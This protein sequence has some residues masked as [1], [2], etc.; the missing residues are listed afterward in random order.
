MVGFL[1]ICRDLSFI[2]A[3]KLRA[4][5]MDLKNRNKL[6]FGNISLKK[7]QLK[8]KLIEFNIV[9]ERQLLG[10]EE[11]VKKIQVQADFEKLLLEPYG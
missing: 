8:A 9:E 3:N 5:K 11:K 10:V 1:S 4:L 2:L 7:S 6:E